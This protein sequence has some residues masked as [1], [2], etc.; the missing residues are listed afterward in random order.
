MQ[1]ECVGSVDGGILA[2]AW[3][4]D[5]ELVMFGTGTGSLLLMTHQ[6][7]LSGDT[8]HELV[9]VTEVSM[10]P[11]EFGKGGLNYYLLTIYMEF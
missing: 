9:P 6:L 10:T 5:Q 4:P 3:S 8:D 11:S 1:V 7:D 2:M